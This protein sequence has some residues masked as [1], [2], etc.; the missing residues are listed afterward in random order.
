MTADEAHARTVSIDVLFGFV[1]DIARFRPDL[2]LIISGA[3]LD[4]V[5]FSDYFDKAP[6]FKCLGEGFC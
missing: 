2:K 5:R 3:T 4:A 1:K 6:I